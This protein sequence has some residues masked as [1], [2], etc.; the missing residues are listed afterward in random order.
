[1]E[2]TRESG[3]EGSVGPE[4]CRI[5]TTRTADLGQSERA[6]IVE[7]CSWAH[8]V[9]FGDLFS[10]LPPDGLHVIARRDADVMAH[11]VLTTRWVR[12]GALPFLRCGYVD[13]VATAPTSQR[14]GIGSA[15][16]RRLAEAAEAEGFELGGLESELRGFYE[17]LGWLRWRGPLAAMTPKGL[18]ATPDQDGIFVLRLARTPPLD[19]DGALTVR[20]DGRFW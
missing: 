18:V 1:M 14:R 17:A 2:G 20:A 7:L 6:A 16:M 3:S 15:V 19:I 10:M 4:G 12:P 13:A 8:G 5:E 11:A 9:D